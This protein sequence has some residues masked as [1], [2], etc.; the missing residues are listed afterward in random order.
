MSRGTTFLLQCTNAIQIGPEA[1]AG[2]Q[3][4]V[5]APV[6]S[7]R[8]ELSLALGSVAAAVR[9]G[10]SFPVAFK[11][12]YCMA[13]RIVKFSILLVNARI[14]P[15]REFRIAAH[16]LGFIVISW[17]IAIICVSVF[18]CTPIAKAWNMSLPGTCINLKGSFIGN[19]VPN[20]LIDVAILSLPRD[21]HR[22]LP[23]LNPLQIEPTDV[24]WTLAE[25]C[26]WCLIETA[27]GIISTCMPSLRPLNNRW[28]NIRL[29]NFGMDGTALRCLVRYGVAAG[30]RDESLSK[31]R[32]QMHVSQDDSSDEVP[33]NT[34]MVT[35]DM[36]WQESTF[37]GTRRWT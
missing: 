29:R 25:A 7:L 13:V 8:S 15:T 16:I 21:I 23:V 30:S 5:P 6:A 34:I 32:V 20:V 19:G 9:N 10:E 4:Q 28:Q 14:L 24:S 2:T 35:R 26:T 33:L 31:S 1:K 11:C 17:V 37:D 18:Q 22:R 3:Q 12:T 36:Q 27:S